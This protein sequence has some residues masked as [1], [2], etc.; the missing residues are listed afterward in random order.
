[1]RPPSPF[2]F[3][4]GLCAFSLAVIT[5]SLSARPEAVEVSST[6]TQLLPK[7]KEA[8]GIIGDF[9]LR[10]NMVEA[11]ISGNLPLRRA[12]MSTFYGADGITPGCLYDL[13]LRGSDN[14][15]ITIFSP[16][17]Q[18]G[19]VSWVRI[20]DPTPSAPGVTAA[21]IETVVTAE[22]AGGISRKH[23]YSIEDG[24]IGVQIT[25]TLRNETDKP[26]KA[27]CQDRWTN[28]LQTGAAPGGI[29]WADAV[30]PADRCGY[31]VGPLH[32]PAG[33]LGLASKELAPGESVVYTRF[34]AV[35]H[36]PAEAV[37]HVC[38]RQGV[39]S[40]L[41]GR[42]LDEAGNPVPDAPGRDH[43]APSGI[44]LSAVAETVAGNYGICHEN[45]AQLTAAQDWIKAQLALNPKDEK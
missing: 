37:S 10:N 7:G 9:V 15:Q 45:A 34:L 11:V 3:V 16:A 40:K 39:Q 30:D 2:R 35:G 20:A 44:A 23:V 29:L 36:S 19:A 26:L 5:P 31:A 13:T 28:F 4:Q 25:T 1:M 6:T 32:D 14:D 27:P 43:D 12:N 33:L 18:Q 22:S 24:W 42:I 21:A 41:S 38:V 8:D 17:S